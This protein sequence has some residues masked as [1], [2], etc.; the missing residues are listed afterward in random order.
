MSYRMRLVSLVN[1]VSV[2]PTIYIWT[3][4]NRSSWHKSL[5]QTKKYLPHIDRL[6]LGTLGYCRM[7]KMMQQTNFSLLHNVSYFTD[8]LVIFFQLALSLVTWSSCVGIWLPRRINTYQSWLL[9]DGL[10]LTMPRSRSRFDDVFQ[11]DM[12]GVI[13]LNILRFYACL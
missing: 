10:F 9:C 5:T 1:R 12:V 6:P 4:C 2:I 3:A 7:L 13:Y 11:N 8:V